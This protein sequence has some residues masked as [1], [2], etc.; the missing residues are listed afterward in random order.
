MEILTIISL[1]ILIVLSILIF[2]KF[3]AVLLRLDNI[4][5]ETR[6]TYENMVN[7]LSS[8]NSK[9][10][11]ENDKAYSNLRIE[12]NN[13]LNNFG[14]LSSSNIKQITD[15]LNKNLDLF[16]NQLKT[17]TVDFNT[18][19]SELTGKIENNL[20]N[21]Q[22]SNEKK[23]DEMRMTVDEK[24][25]ST[26]EKRLSESFS[27]VSTRLEQ[28]HKGLGEMQTLASGVGDLKKVLSN[29][30]N[31]G[32]WGEMQLK[33]LLE[34]IFA[35]DQYAENV[36]VKSG[37]RENVEFAI[38][39]P[40]KGDQKDEIV[41]LP[42]D[43]KFPLEDYQNLVYAQENGDID[44]I[45]EFKKALINR[46]KSEA[47]SISKK[48]IN[49]PVTTDF[50]VL[51]LPLESLFAEVLSVPGLYDSIQQ[52]QKV[53]ITG[54]T[55]LYAFLGSL[56]MGFRTLAIQ[57]RS[58]EVWNLL[59]AIKTDFN[60]FG[61]LLEKT[62]QKLD[63]ASKEIEAAQKQTK[64]IEKK[65]GNVDSLPTPEEVKLLLGDE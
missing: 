16:A 7:L 42:I 48:Y 45:N 34:Q 55:T 47:D 26:L 41:Y 63:S 39:L 43:S 2:T 44:A 29:V 59:G 11:T 40:G 30:K 5:N 50:A 19:L 17:L 62:Q 36:V 8:E 46:I 65:L 28:V 33:T 31:R 24:L 37:S 60:K 10:R 58:S 4:Q 54:P 6:R 1:I 3:S 52:N 51:F 18:R 22:E 49:P 56:Q 13:Q 15:V 12:L 53:V 57:K 61:E 14:N 64:K 38:K 23:L 9:I 32:V 35:S 21:I 20:K 27:V 25:H